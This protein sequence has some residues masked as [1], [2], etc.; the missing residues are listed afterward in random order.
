VLTQDAVPCTSATG[1]DLPKSYFG[2][3]SADYCNICDRILTT[4]LGAFVSPSSYG[5]ECR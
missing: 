2:D 3:V 4:K 1:S 5:S